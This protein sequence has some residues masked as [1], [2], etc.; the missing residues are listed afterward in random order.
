MTS[1][2]HSFSRLLNVDWLIQISP[3]AR[4]KIYLGLIFLR[5][6]G[7]NETI[8]EIPAIFADKSYPLTPIPPGNIN[9][10]EVVSKPVASSH[11]MK[12]VAV[13]V[14]SVTPWKKHLKNRVVDL[15]IKLVEKNLSVLFLVSYP[16][17]TQRSPIINHVTSSRDHTHLSKVTFDPFSHWSILL[18]GIT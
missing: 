16:P 10:V 3:Y 12:L 14:P 9:A 15:V 17:Y 18:T 1:G 2:H 7:V 13:N 11:P 6:I 4:H 5:F 8:F